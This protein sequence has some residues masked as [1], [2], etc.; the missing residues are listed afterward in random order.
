MGDPGALVQVI[1]VE[2]RSFPESSESSQVEAGD[3]GMDRVGNSETWSEVWSRED[4][5]GC[6][7]GASVQLTHLSLFCILF[8][9]VIRC[10]RKEA[11]MLID[12]R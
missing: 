2:L 3:M 5:R 1:G 10:S 7:G 8:P 9:R 6:C 11:G 4:L 12:M